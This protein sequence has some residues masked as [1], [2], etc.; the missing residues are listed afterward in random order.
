[1]IG[2]LYRMAF[3]IAV[4]MFHV[5]A[6]TMIIDMDVVI[7]I[8]RAVALGACVVGFVIVFVVIGLASVLLPVVL[9]NR[10]IVCFCR[11]SWYCCYAR[12]RIRARAGARSRA[13]ARERVVWTDICCGC[14]RARRRESVLPSVHV[15][16]SARACASGR[17][18]ETY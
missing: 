3:I 10:F 13:H 14:A 9:L 5:A 11:R 16:E 18:R 2:I 17:T 4:L 1:M 7:T 12:V 8:P 15:R 6:I